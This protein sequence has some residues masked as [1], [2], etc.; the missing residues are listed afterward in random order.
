MADEKED[1]ARVAETAL[2][3]A[4]AARKALEA[5]IEFAW[6]AEYSSLTAAQV[7]LSARGAP[8]KV[9]NDIGARALRLVTRRHELTASRAA[10]RIIDTPPP[11]L[12]I[13]W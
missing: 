7:E 13:F 10:D 4:E 3:K 5:A 2:R 6:D 8:V 12:W 1:L 11:K 9:I